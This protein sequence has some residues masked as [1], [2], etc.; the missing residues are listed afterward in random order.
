MG[1]LEEFLLKLNAK[2]INLNK[3]KHPTDYNKLF[4]SGGAAEGTR[5][6]LA[7][8][9]AI[10]RMIV[11]SANETPSSIVIDTPN[12][13]DQANINYQSII[14]LIMED[15]PSNSQVIL[16]AMENTDIEPYLSS[17]KVIELDKNKLLNK[18]MY[19]K[20]DGELSSIIENVVSST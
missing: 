3:I 16:C 1:L 15:I 17:A 10:Y 9:I 12:Q 19:E 7:Y 14:R 4:R 8:Q 13:Q 18:E 11:S 2:E 20:L 5:A 6:A